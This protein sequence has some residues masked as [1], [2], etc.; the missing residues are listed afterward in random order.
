MFYGPTISR[1]HISKASFPGTGP[2]VKVNAER[3]V[4]LLRDGLLPDVRGLYPDGDFIFQQDGAT[5]HTSNITQTFLDQE[6]VRF[7]SKEDWP[8]NSAD[9]NPMDYGIWT[10]LSE[11]V[12]SGRTAPFNEEE[13]KEKITAC[14][15]ALSLESVRRVILAWKRRLRDVISADGGAMEHL[16]L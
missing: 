14:W 12:F 4:T 16:R 9:L 13:L 15:D 7:I 3:Y 8:P 2:S 5:S 6:Q 1:N 10:Q 11:A